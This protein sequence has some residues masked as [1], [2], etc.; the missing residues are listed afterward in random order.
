M[1]VGVFLLISPTPSLA[2]NKVMPE[3]LKTTV[4]YIDLPLGADVYWPAVVEK[5]SDVVRIQ[6]YWS[7]VTAPKR[8]HATARMVWSD[9]G[10]W[11]LFEG[12]QQEPLVV[13]ENPN[14]TKKTHGLWN[15][16]VFEIFL[17][18]EA[19]EPKR[20]FEFEVAPTGE[21]IDL[22]LNSTSGKRVTDRE[23]DSGMGV[24]AVG[25]RNEKIQ[26][27]IRIPWKALG[28]TPKAGDVWLG[29]LLRCIGK[30]PDRGYL[31]WS[32]TM[33]KT[34]NFHVPERFGEFHFVR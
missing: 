19:S 24:V 8:R 20:Y 29:N 12:N 27:L 18:P 15:R 30:D 2:Q 34:P 21:W 1:L 6:K 17:A 23:Y 28:K 22:A 26:A 9:E 14:T 32:P 4:R 16:D 3:K 13:S 5:H 7:G 10:L 25:N 11:V 31:T 33:T